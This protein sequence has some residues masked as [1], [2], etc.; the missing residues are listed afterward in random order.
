MRVVIQRVR[1][2]SVTIADQKV[3]EITG[4]MVVLVG[5]S[6]ND[7]P[8]DAEYLAH[9]TANLRIFADDSGK[10]NRS[11]IDC[12]GQVLVVSQFTLYGDC[13]RGNRPDFF[14]AAAPDGAQCLYEYYVK[15]LQS[16]GLSVQT[17]VFQADML[18]DIANDGPVTIIIESKAK[19]GE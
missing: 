8:A 10:L 9:K 16:Y 19:K 11:L 18:V 17:G 5:I 13:R 12:G 6:K 15:Q 7:K 2:A 14:T 3:A 1:Q 4:G